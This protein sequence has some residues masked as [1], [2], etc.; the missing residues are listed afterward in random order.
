MRIQFF[1]STFAKPINSHFEKSRSIYDYQHLLV[2]PYER[3]REVP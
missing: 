1:R 2:H 3:V